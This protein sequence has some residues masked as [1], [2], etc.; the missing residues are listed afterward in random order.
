[1]TTTNGV[2]PVRTKALELANE[3]RAGLTLPPNEVVARANHYHAFL[4]GA[5][6]PTATNKTPTPTAG[7]TGPT[8]GGGGKPPAQT[9]A[10]A[11]GP[12]KPQ[13]QTQAP[14]ATTKAPATTTGAPKTAT[15]TKPPAA[16]TGAPK[17]TTSKPPAAGG[18]PPAAG[19]GGQPTMSDV[20]LALQAVFGK[21]GGAKGQGKEVAYALLAKAGSGAASAKDLKP[22]LYSAVIKAC[23]D[24]QPEPAGEA[25][26][27]FAE[28]EGT[29]VVVPDTSGAAAPAPPINADDDALDSDPPEQT[30]GG[31]GAEDL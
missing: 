1:M 16:T 19:G 8:S 2:D 25:E 14:A 7:A 6:A 11:P 30:A 23:N 20:T 15:T 5:P 13:A 24:W 3:H 31:A 22:A 18:K 12:A 21:A 4:T 17:T 28:S 26:P 9:S 29:P 10:T 27:D